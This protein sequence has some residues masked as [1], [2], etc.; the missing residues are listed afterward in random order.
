MKKQINFKA[1]LILTLGG[2]ALATTIHFV[3]AAQVRR[4]AS[5]LLEEAKRLEE[6]GEKYL[7]AENFAAYLG[8]RPDDADAKAC[9]A[10]LL[11]KLAKSP[12]ERMKA[13]FILSEAW[14]T[15]K[16]RDDV[17][18]ELAKLALML[19]R[20]DEVRDHLNKLLE[21]EPNSSELLA[22]RARC[23]DLDKEESPAEEEIGTKEEYAAKEEGVAGMW[24]KKAVKAAPADVAISME[25]A[26][27]LNQRNLP[28]R[29]KRSSMRCSRQ[30]A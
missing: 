24:Y 16:T 26:Y 25:Y 27:Y 5:A 4:T 21:A 15:D 6:N 7:A 2:A 20:Y 12:K 23:A 8:L 9:L 3:H 30:R 28:L 13:Y 1:V 17:R 29:G 22:M 18:R 10:L 14:R 11:T 19:A